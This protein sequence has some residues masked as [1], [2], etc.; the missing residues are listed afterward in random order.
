MLGI[1]FLLAAAG[2][3]ISIS[4]VG[5]IVIALIANETDVA[6]RLTIHLTLG[7]FVSAALLFAIAGRGRRIPQIGA[8]IMAALLWILLPIIAAL[9]FSDVAGIGYLDGLFEVASGLTTTGASALTNL[10]AVPKSVLFFRS[11]LEWI[12]GYLTILTML[13]VLS[14]SGVGGMPLLA[15][16]SLPGRNLSSSGGRTSDI[17]LLVARYYILT[18]M[19][20]F[21]GL[22]L[23]GTRPFPAITLS[24][25]A[26]STGGFV[27]YEVS[28]DQLAGPFSLLILA[29][30]LMVGATS[31]FW[32]RAILRGNLVALKLHRESYSII[33]VAAILALAV[34][35]T[36]YRISGSSGSEA[37]MSAVVEGVF[38]AASIVSTSGVETREGVVAILPIMLVLLV[39]FVG[40]SIHSTS[41]GV[42][43]FRIGA[44]LI[45][46]KREMHTLIYPSGVLG[47]RYGSQTYDVN[48]I[49][50]VWSALG[51][52]LVLVTVATFLLSFNGLDFD[53]ALMAAVAAFSTAGP[54]YE[55]GWAAHGAVGWPSYVDMNLGAKLTLILTMIL[56]RVEVLVVLGALNLRYWLRS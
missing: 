17:A 2:A 16:S 29:A 25:M 21:L 32:Q 45:Q 31:I 12:G 47:A 55:S 22:M 46:C 7:V 10:G 18:T 3:L 41:G 27:P 52:A 50:A 14:P 30:V 8:F 9:P 37:F 24:M 6:A 51:A 48:Q 44:M 4:L 28:L 39:V 1:I 26:V 54:I 5:P 38:T 34:S 11:Q 13:V 23:T 53:A 19:L 20:C 35:A 40:G 33:I 49:K 56:G 15:A 43:H 36:L 42:S